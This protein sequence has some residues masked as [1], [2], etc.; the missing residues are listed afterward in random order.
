MG[1]ICALRCLKEE[2]AGAIVQCY[3]TM[4]LKNKAILNVKQYCMYCY[5]AFSNA[6]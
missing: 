2:L 3:T 6:F 1:V 5:V 4:E